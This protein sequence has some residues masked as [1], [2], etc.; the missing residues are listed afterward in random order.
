MGTDGS[1]WKQMG[2][3]GNRWEAMGTDENRWEQMGT[4]AVIETFL[5]F[6]Y[7]LNIEE[8]A[9]LNVMHHHQNPIQLVLDLLYAFNLV[10]QSLLLFIGN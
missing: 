6:I 8:G 10:S 2:T 7:F 1:R 3:D 5:K 4:D 9:V